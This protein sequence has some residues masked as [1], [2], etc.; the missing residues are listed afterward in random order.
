MV[1]PSIKAKL[2]GEN[3]SLL[4]NQKSRDRYDK[5]MRDLTTKAEDQLEATRRNNQISAL[6]LIDDQL[7]PKDWTGWDPSKV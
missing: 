6:N 3:F 4:R 2:A 5:R 7:G 1:A